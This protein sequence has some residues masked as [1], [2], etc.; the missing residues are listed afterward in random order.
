MKIS[1]ITAVLTPDCE[2]A[3]TCASIDAQTHPDVE[4]ITIY[5]RGGAP[6]GRTAVQAPAAGVYAALNAG[7][8]LAKGDA[9]GLLHSGDTLASPQILAQVAQ[10]LQ[11]NPK[12]DF[13]FGD[14]AYV[15][16]GGG[17]RGRRM[18]GA[19]PSVHDLRRG[20]Y[21]PHPTLYLRAE[22]ARRLGLYAEDYTICGDMD[23]WVRI[24]QA[25]LRGV[26][27]PGVMVEMTTG[28]LSTRLR[29]RLLTN[30]REKLRVLRAH[31]LGANPLLLASKYARV[32]KELWTKK[33]Q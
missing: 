10:T 24:V 21:P 30:N 9:V 32:A 4:H 25:G 2:Y 17:R 22:A 20:I 14:V 29:A 8:R 7:L 12:A 27:I 13:T 3:R 23:M 16:P 33:R 26:R 11:E 1:I 15:P 6:Q 19:P 28:G 5:S 18:C 31:R